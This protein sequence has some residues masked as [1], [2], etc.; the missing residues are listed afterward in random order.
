MAQAVSHRPLT[1]EDR[2]RSREG[3]TPCGICG[4]LSLVTTMTALFR[5]PKLLWSNT[6]LIFTNI[7]PSC[8]AFQLHVTP[9]RTFIAYLIAIKPNQV[10]AMLRT[11]CSRLLFPL[12]ERPFL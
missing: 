5:I 1:A 4:G 8:M 6:K 10:D 3:V 7:I 11:W 9:P 12:P 2:V